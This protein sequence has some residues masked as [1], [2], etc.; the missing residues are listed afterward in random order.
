MALDKFYFS[1]LGCDDT[2]ISRSDII[3]DID[4]ENIYYLHNIW[5]KP[6]EPL[7]K[8]VLAYYSDYYNISSKYR[9]TSYY[10]IY[11]GIRSFDVISKQVPLS[12]KKMYDA[13]WNKMKKMFAHSFLLGNPTEEQKQA[14]CKAMARYIVNE[15]RREVQ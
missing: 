2:R 11:T 3:A 13:L 10:S 8:R 14:I 1:K 15:A 5:L 6:N 7:Y 9:F 4:A 12:E